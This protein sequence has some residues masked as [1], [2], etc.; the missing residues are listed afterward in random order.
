MAP[1]EEPARSVSSTRL[2]LSKKSAQ[3]RV[4]IIR[5]LV[6][7]L[8]TVTFIAAWFWCSVC[9]SSSGDCPRAASCSSSHRRAGVVCGILVA[10]PLHELDREGGGQGRGL[11]ALEGEGSTGPAAQAEEVVRER[12][13]GLAGRASGHDALGEPPEVLHE[14]DAEGD[15]DRPELADGQR[16]HPLER[17]DEALE[18]LG[19]ES[20]VGVRDEGPRQ[21]EHAGIPLQRTLRELG[22]LAVEPRRQ[23]LA[24]LA[25]HRVHHVEV[26]DEPL[27]GRSRRSLVADHGSD[28]AIAQEENP[29]AVPDP[30]REAASGSLAGQDPLAGDRLRVL[31]EPLRAEELGPDGLLG[32]RREWGRG[33]GEKGVARWH[34]DLY[35]DIS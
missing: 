29:P 11:E 25:H 2:T 20:A 18:G 35:S 23:I 30:G 22:Q 8:R 19:L 28:L 12:V 15:R 26:V 27:R 21:S 17:A 14:H 24:N 33:S 31:L 9:T 13:G 7:T 1:K 4:D 3:S 10:Q 32:P 6:I 16:L 5:M 34:R